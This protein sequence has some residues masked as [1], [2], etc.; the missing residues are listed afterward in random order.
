MDLVRLVAD[1]LTGA[2]DGGSPFAGRGLATELCVAD[3]S[4]AAS[5]ARV[6][7]TSTASRRLPA[8]LAARRVGEHLQRLPVAPG[9]LLVK[10]IDSLLR[11]PY[12]AE[13]RELMRATG[14]R[15]A[16][17]SPALPRLDRSLRGGMLQVDGFEIPDGHLIAGEVSSALP[18]ALA[19][20]FPE[21]PRWQVGV[22]A[23][24]PLP[25]AGLLVVDAGTD[26]DLDA[27]VAH[28]WAVRGDVVW[29]G[30]SGLTQALAR[31]A[32]GD[33]VPAAVAPRLPAPPLLLVVGSRT[34]RARGQVQALFEGDGWTHGQ[35]PD[36][37][38]AAS[39][40][41]AAS[42]SVKVLLS[43]EQEIAS[44]LATALLADAAA[45]EVF[46]G[47]RSLAVVGG[48]TLAALM[49]RL[50][51]ARVC[52]LGPA[53]AGFEAIS[54]RCRRVDAELVLYSR[55]G[56]FGAPG[57]LRALCESVAGLSC[58]PCQDPRMPP[59]MLGPNDTR[60]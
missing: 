45:G 59:P 29:V 48:E 1:D 11:G 58:E 46:S 23:L 18:L 12:A 38:E 25:G 53:M 6:L 35:I 39:L 9:T 41:R 40:R 57:D 19:T 4:A 47:I 13:L 54:V 56:S 55:S 51:P 20:A 36:G 21:L 44:E 31:R 14:R 10:K 37:R 26:A 24:P 50:E 42:A 3:F 15:V 34:E 2:L 27:L 32:A 30:S 7:V 52:V 28:Y 17:V 5:R 60:R 22:D 49:D 16:L 43:P 33:G 8:M